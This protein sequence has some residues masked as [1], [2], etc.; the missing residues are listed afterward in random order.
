MSAINLAFRDITKDDFA[1]LLSEGFSVETN[2]AILG[3][4]IDDYAAKIRFMGEGL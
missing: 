2:C 4:S 3:C 1:A